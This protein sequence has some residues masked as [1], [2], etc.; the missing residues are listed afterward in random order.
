MKIPF[1]IRLF[2]VMKKLPRYIIIHDINCMTPNAESLRIDNKKFQTAKMRILQY[3][4][5]MQADLNYHFIVDRIDKDYEVILG[6]P[7]ATLCEYDDIRDPYHWSFHIGV[8]GNYD[9]DIPE[10]R[11]YQKIAYNILSPMIKLY[12]I[13]PTRVLLHSE[14]NKEMQCPGN[15]FDKMKL[16][17]YLKMMRLTG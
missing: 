8:M 15:Y 2:D 11:L 16:M 9:Y 4:K 5:H 1:K 7:L 17:S 12:K 14:I 3:Q 10:L 13:D 6:R